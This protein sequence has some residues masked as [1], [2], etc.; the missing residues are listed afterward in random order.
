MHTTLSTFSSSLDQRRK[1]MGLSFIDLTRETGLSRQAIYRLFHGQDV[2][3]TTL[4]AVC[5]V[6]QLDVMAVPWGIASLVAEARPPSS[7]ATL[8]GH[9]PSVS[10]GR[11]T[12]PQQ[13]VVSAQSSVPSALEMRM[14]R[15]RA[16]TEPG[17]GDKRS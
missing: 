6:L 1:A 15:L 9:A 4:L 2:Q 3:L 10:T 11:S 17:Q 12:V 14:S 8:A 16:G 7:S 13:G 5:K